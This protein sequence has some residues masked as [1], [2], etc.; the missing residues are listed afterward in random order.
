[1]GGHGWP[2]NGHGSP[3]GLSFGPAAT[4][5]LTDTAAW[6]LITSNAPGRGLA[7]LPTGCAAWPAA[8]GDWRLATGDWRLASG[9]SVWP[10]DS[11]GLGFAI[12]WL[13]P[14]S[15]G[16]AYSEGSIAGVLRH[17]GIRAAMPALHAALHPAVRGGQEYIHYQINPDY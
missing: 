8:T 6:L 13:G 10:R 15:A 3:F 14:W 12:A 2:W 1:M 4:R 9:Q 5:L 7:G 17:C 11:R 16:S